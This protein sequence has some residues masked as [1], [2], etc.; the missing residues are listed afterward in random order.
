M[1]KDTKR[2]LVGFVDNFKRPIFILG[3]MSW[4]ALFIIIS[5][6]SFSLVKTGYAISSSNVLGVGGSE[7]V[8]LAFVVLS[9]LVFLIW[10]YL[11]RDL[12]KNKI[13]MGK[14]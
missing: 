1:D 7:F 14:K 2:M 10:K 12:R 13:K 4:I 6:E 3:I 8:V 11:I 5:T 9:I